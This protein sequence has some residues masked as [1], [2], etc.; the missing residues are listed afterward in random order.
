M[1][2]LESLLACI[3]EIFNTKKKISKRGF[4]SDFESARFFFFF[5]NIF[6]VLF[7]TVECQYV[8]GTLNYVRPPVVEGNIKWLEDTALTKRHHSCLK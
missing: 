4:I 8:L 7:L 3:K 1:H 2:I 5:E 6:G